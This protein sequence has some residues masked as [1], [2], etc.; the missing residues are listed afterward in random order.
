MNLKFIVIF[1][2]FI[3]VAVY[4]PYSTNDAQ[5]I[6][7]FPYEITHYVDPDTGYLIVEG[8]LGNDSYISEPFGEVNYQFKFFDSERN[9]LFERDFSLT[10][11]VS[12]DGG[13]VIPPGITLPFHIVIDDV[14]KEIINK[15]QS[16]RSGSTN[17]LEYFLWK[18]ADLKIE[19]NG[20]ERIATIH[21]QTNQN[22]FY[23]WKISGTITNM[24]S[25][26]A[27]NVYV[28]ASLLEGEYGFLGTAGYWKDVDIQPLNLNG[29]ETKDFVIH[30]VLP[31][32]KIPDNVNIYAESDK[33]TFVH[34][35][36]KPL[37][38]K[39]II[40]HNGRFAVDPKKHIIISANVTNISRDNFDT[41]WIIQIKKSPKNINE[42]D[43]TKYPESTVEIIERIPI[44]IDGQKSMILEYPW[45]PQSGGI[46]FYEM[47][48]WNEE[49]IPISYPFTGNFLSQGE[50]FVSPNLYSIKNQINSGT[51]FN[52][53]VCKEG[54]K[55]AHKASN[56]NFVCVKSE[57]ISKLMERGWIKQT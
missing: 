40:D 50:M 28:V 49:N 31:N 29:F 9:L 18:P 15:I 26:K 11:G 8:Q 45:M 46:Y 7:C 19:V 24:H 27:E 36:Y 17:T 6:C 3:C 22:I 48:L 23:K 38:L 2:L 43:W 4:L 35:Y 52:E 33:S 57:S 10:D 12:I 1:F 16:V 51:P 39:N 42:G 13:F 44:R 56:A 47:F 20:L 37:I 14:E 21:D 53:L 25:E 41:Q 32:D 34:Q 54:L 55:L 5:A 30:S